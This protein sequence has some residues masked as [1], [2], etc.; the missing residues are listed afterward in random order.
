MQY[1]EKKLK[2]YLL[3]LLQQPRSVF[4]MFANSAEP[5]VLQGCDAEA[6]SVVAPAPPSGG[7]D[8]FACKSKFLLS[9]I[10]SEANAVSA[11]ERSVQ[12]AR[13]PTAVNFVFDKKELPL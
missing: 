5:E 4:S 12:Y 7:D 10:L 13:R 3:C 6:S 2:I 1:L 8:G 9:V 11:V